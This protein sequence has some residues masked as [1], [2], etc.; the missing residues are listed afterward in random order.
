[1]TVASLTGL[2]SAESLR[3]KRDRENAMKPQSICQAVTLAPRAVV[4]PLCLNQEETPFGTLKLPSNVYIAS[5][6]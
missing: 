3:W 2:N 4:V 6:Y 5:Y 1:M